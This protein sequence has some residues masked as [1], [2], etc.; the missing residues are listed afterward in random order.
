MRTVVQAARCGVKIFTGL[1]EMPVVVVSGASGPVVVVPGGVSV[2][3]GGGPLVLVESSPTKE[4]SSSPLP[5][6][7]ARAGRQSASARREERGA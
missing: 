6:P 3:P 7:H 5:V 1:R 4:V 2:V